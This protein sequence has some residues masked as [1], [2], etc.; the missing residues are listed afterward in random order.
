MTLYIMSC[1]ND[2]KLIVIDVNRFLQFL[3]K[4]EWQQND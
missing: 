3:Y 4:K 1:L 2:E